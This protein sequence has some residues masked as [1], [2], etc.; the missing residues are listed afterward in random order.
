M[1]YKSFADLSQDIKFNLHK[2]PRDVSLIVGIPRSG[3]LAANLMAVYLNLPLTDID[4]FANRKILSTG[5]RGKHYEKDA[6][7]GKILIVDDSSLA[8][9]TTRHIYVGNWF[10]G[11]FIVVTAM[12]HI[13]NKSHDQ[14]RCLHS[15][16]RFAMPGQAGNSVLSVLRP[17]DLPPFTDEGLLARARAAPAGPGVPGAEAP[18]RAPSRA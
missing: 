2:I 3:L 14:S 12:L 16:L 5:F 8:R 15:C 7:N 10:Y 9:R 1:N 11:A 17:V 4:S 18:C 13:V 6:F